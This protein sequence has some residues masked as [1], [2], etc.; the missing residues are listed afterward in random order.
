M[1]S[2]KAA[3]CG[4]ASSVS[5]AQASG[6]GESERQGA[7]AQGRGETERPVDEGHGTYL[8]LMTGLASA[9][10]RWKLN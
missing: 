6:E 5:A 9:A 2:K 10:A 3:R 7:D 1:G 8:L 4:A